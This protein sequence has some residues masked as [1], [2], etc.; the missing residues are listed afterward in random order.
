MCRLEGATAC[1]P[2]LKGA[3]ACYPRPTGTRGSGSRLLSSVSQPL[4]A[5]WEWQHIMLLLCGNVAHC[6]APINAQSGAADPRGG[7]QE[8]ASLP[9]GRRLTRLRFGSY[10]IFSSIVD[11]KAARAR[12]AAARSGGVRHLPIKRT[13][14]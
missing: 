9:T 5:Q 3:T 6:F 1:C 4:S 2:R 12:G 11:F 13:H 14:L 10:G 8:Q 7:A